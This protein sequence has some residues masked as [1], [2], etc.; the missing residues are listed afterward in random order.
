MVKAV[1]TPDCPDR[2]PACSDR[3]AKYAA[4]K[5]ERKKEKEY[6]KDQI[7]AGKLNKNDF[8]A[9]FWMGGRHR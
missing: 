3:C 6:T 8:D 2:H 9:E 5:A 1:C 4:W 7:F